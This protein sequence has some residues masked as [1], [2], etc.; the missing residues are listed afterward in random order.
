MSLTAAMGKNKNSAILS[1][2]A[3]S[4]NEEIEH[5]GSANGSAESISSVK[6]RS[7]KAQLRFTLPR[8][9]IVFIFIVVGIVASGGYFNQVVFDEDIQ[10]ARGLWGAGVRKRSITEVC[11]WCC[12]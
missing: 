7:V 12:F 3:T 10:S 11:T 4:D 2:S 1:S 8:E 6:S 5:D 9:L